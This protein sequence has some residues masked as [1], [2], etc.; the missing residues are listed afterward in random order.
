MFEQLRLDGAGESPELVDDGSPGEAE[1]T[2]NSKITSDPRADASKIK[3]IPRAHSNLLQRRTNGTTE[4]VGSPLSKSMRASSIIEPEVPL[5]PI[6]TDFGNIKEHELEEECAEESGA[7]EY[8]D[9][10]CLFLRPYGVLLTFT[11]CAKCHSRSIGSRP[12][13]R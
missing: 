7:E 12:Y 11:A 6:R 9:E 13:C 4:A 10:V 5:E 2:P 8:T 1:V 3:P